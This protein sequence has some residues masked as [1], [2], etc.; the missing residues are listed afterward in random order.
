MGNTSSSQSEQV[1]IESLRQ[2]LHKLYSNVFDEKNLQSTVH[3][4]SFPSI[5]DQLYKDVFMKLNSAREIPIEL[6]EQIF[7]KKDPV[8]KQNNEV[9]T[10]TIAYYMK[11]INLVGVIILAVRMAHLK[12]ERLRNGTGCYGE[13]LLGPTTIK[14]HP[15]QIG[16]FSLN[17][18]DNVI[19]NVNINKNVDELKRH[20]ALIEI[21]NENVCQEQGGVWKETNTDE[22]REY[23]VGYK[24]K[25]DK[26]ELEVYQSISELIHTMEKCIEERIEPR[27]IDGK[28]H[29]VK[30]FRDRII[31]N[32]DLNTCSI[33]AKQ[34]LQNLFIKLDSFYLKSYSNVVLKTISRRN[35]KSHIRSARSKTK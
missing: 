9:L 31:Y 5:Q 3:P 11:K 10:E 22:Y 21:D 17:V 34:L 30:V 27:M 7:Y 29:R 13:N 2:N 33:K 26:L 28:E 8:L 18:R 24:K 12:L 20:I 1:S 25:L 19:K 15:I 23:P 4:D 16:L 6:R 14:T 32:T 35:K